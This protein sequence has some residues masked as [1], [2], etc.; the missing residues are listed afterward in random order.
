MNNT[1]KN[2]IVGGLA[3]FGLV[4]LISSSIS[5]API[6]EGTQESS[7]WGMV[8]AGESEKVVAFLFNKKTGEVRRCYVNKTEYSKPYT[9]R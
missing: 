7:V 5:P 2:S 6:Q 8:A 9:E 3:I 1:F 4:S